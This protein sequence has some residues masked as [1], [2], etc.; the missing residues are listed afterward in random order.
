[1]YHIFQCG[2]CFYLLNQLLTLLL[3]LYQELLNPI[4]TYK[5]T[6][7]KRWLHM[8]K[9]QPARLNQQNMRSFGY[10]SSAHSSAG[11][12]ANS[13]FLLNMAFAGY[14]MSCQVNFLP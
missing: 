5:H 11:I 14:R 13:L 1:M 12:Q 6:S 7:I 4:K 10:C 3:L 8:K 9:N 2:W